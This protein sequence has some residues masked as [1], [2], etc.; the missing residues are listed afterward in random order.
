MNYNSPFLVLDTLARHYFHDILHFLAVNALFA[1]A[2]WTN[3]KIVRVFIGFAATGLAVCAL[4]YFRIHDDETAALFLY[5]MFPFVAVAAAVAFTRLTVWLRQRKD[6]WGRAAPTFLSLAALVSITHSFAQ[7]V[8]HIALA[9]APPYAEFSDYL[10]KRSLQH[11]KHIYIVMPREDRAFGALESM[12]HFHFVGRHK[13]EFTPY[14]RINAAGDCDE[15]VRDWAGEARSAGYPRGLYVYLGSVDRA[16]AL[17]LHN[18]KLHWGV[19]DQGDGDDGWIYGYSFRRFRDD[20]PYPDR[21]VVIESCLIDVSSD[22][23]S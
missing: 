11:R 14:R 6:V 5:F 10:G 4:S 1:A 2:W 20:D 16:R 17:K 12:I 23:G 19:F 18:Q 9:P 7:T 3:I 13:S 15:T 8:S 22:Q 21:P